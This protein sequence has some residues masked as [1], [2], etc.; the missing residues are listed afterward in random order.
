ML[1]NELKTALKEGN[2]AGIYIFC[3][4]ENFLK[5]H[6]MRE[7]RAALLPDPT[8]DAFNR[9]VL[10][11]EKVDFF[12]LSEAVK[13]P[14]M[15]AEHK[16]V[17]WHLADFNAMREGDFEKLNNLSEEIKDYPE[18]V[19]VFSVDADRMD[20]G[21]L[22]KRPSKLYKTVSELASVVCFEKSGEAALA[23][24]INRHFTHEGVTAA[25]ATVRALLAQSGTSM[26]TLSGEIDKLC[27][28]VKAN[29]RT[30]IT[31][32]DVRE[33][34]CRVSESEAFGLSNA[35]LDGDA[36]AA[37][38]CLA[39][40][41]GRRVDPILAIGS[42]IK[43]FN[44]MLTVALAAADGGKP[45][46]IAAALKMHEFKVSLYLRAA[47]R[48]D[49]AAIADALT[50]CRR[51]DAATKSGEGVGGYLALEYLIARTLP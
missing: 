41:R 40:L 46:D 3:G 47:A 21:T 6:Y 44:D 17:E 48:R 9:M 4:E 33:I 13:A 7:M 19:V 49:I 32:E 10:E 43:I 42:V 36:A 8:F 25:P 39:D 22:P 16:L 35:I 29:G 15:M 24:W 27:A 51:A 37:Y 1:V 28:Y 30:E 23:S 11:G 12:S 14:P 38:T 34:A 26:D 20:V 2:L 50:L 31:E 45:K 5:R 18:T